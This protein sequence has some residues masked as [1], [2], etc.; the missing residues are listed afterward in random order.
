[1]KTRLCQFA[2]KEGRGKGK[3]KD[4]GPGNHCSLIPPLAGD[5]TRAFQCSIISC[6]DLERDFSIH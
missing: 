2:L 6:I 5:K 1:M 3:K 4:P